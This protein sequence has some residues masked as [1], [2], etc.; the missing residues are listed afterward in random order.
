MVRGKLVEGLA[1]VPSGTQPPNPS[2]LLGGERIQSVLD[3]LGREY[4][5]VII[6]TPPLL[7]A[8]DA[9]VLGASADG[10]VLVVGAG[11]TEG[12]PA[13]EAISS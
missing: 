3:A 12:G 2:E 4:D 13:Q 8:S 5:V 10:V 6:D 7:A 11:Q 1:I 9:A